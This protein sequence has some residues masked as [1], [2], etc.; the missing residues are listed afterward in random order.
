MAAVGISPAQANPQITS[1]EH[2]PDDV[3]SGSVPTGHMEKTKDGGL[4]V[5]RNGVEVSL[6]GNSSKP[7]T[8][9]SA[10]SR[11]QVTLPASTRA[12]KAVN[13]RK[14]FPTFN[15]G[16]GSLTTTVPKNDGS[17]QIVTT[18]E[19]ATAPTEY[20]YTLGLKPGSVLHELNGGTI[21]I[22][23][24]DG[25]EF[26]GGIAAPWAKDANSKAIPTRYVID[27]TKLTQIID[28][29][30]DGIA[31]PVVAD[32]WFGIDL[33]YSPY[34]SFVSQGY[35]INVTPTN[36]GTNINN[37]GIET[38]WAHRDEVKTKLGGNAWRWTNSIQ[39]QFYCHIRGI[40]ASLPEYNMESWRPT[41]NWLESLTR[42]RCNPYDGYWS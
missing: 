13:Q 10:K 6:P 22:L 2:L 34:V 1:T 28:H 30:A 19:S 16:D 32:P 20:T 29:R 21:A 26:L 37:T 18:I 7:A 27:G 24:P 14:E 39:E 36:W 23:T 3:K 12:S 25:D 11:I 33:Y 9:D 5:K 17:L 31:Y 35:K 38:W 8:L 40:P 4:R 15:N 42:Y 41:I